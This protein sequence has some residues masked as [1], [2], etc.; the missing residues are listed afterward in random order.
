MAAL[1]GNINT[2]KRVNPTPG[3]STAQAI[4][5]ASKQNAAGVERSLNVAMNPRIFIGDREITDIVRVELD[6][7]LDQVALGTSIGVI[8]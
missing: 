7:Q 3:L 2:V 6:D 5:L 4:A 1:A 8:G